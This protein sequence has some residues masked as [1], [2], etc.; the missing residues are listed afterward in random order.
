MKQKRSVRSSTRKTQRP[1]SAH[2]GWCGL[3]ALC[4]VLLANPDGAAAAS[5]TAQSATPQKPAWLTDIS[6]GLKE[7]YDNN[8]LLVSGDGMGEE[9]SWIT[10]VSPKIGIN[11]VPLLGEQDTLKL[12]TLNY[13][14]DFVAYHNAEDETYN[15]H[16]LANTL[17]G[18]VEAFTFTMDNALVYVD[19]NKTAPTYPVPDNAR[20]AYATAAA[21]ERREQFQDRAKVTLQYDWERFLI[22][23]T[24]SLLY[25]DLLT[26]QS[27][28]VGYQN[29]A[30]RYDINGGADFGYKA[31]AQTTLLL[32][33]RYGHQYQETIVGTTRSSCS[34]Y[35]RVLVGIEGKPLKWLTLSVQ[36]G[37]DFRSYD[38]DAP[39]DDQD[40]VKL[41]GEAT[42]T[43]DL[44]AKDALT[45]KYRGFQWVSSTGVIPYFDSTYDLSYRHKF[46]S[47]LTVEAGARLLTSD[48]NSGNTPTSKRNDWMYTFAG[49]VTY[50]VTA[51]FALNAAVAADLGRN[52]QKDIA[53][54]Q[55]RE[56]DRQLVSLGMTVKF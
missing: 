8:V 14:P 10:T 37:P 45:F 15:A 5:P 38:N 40:C 9:Y 43:A 31:A 33:W 51:N 16:R 24:A 35:Q 2:S 1:V 55:Y 22:R 21:R 44:S 7:G 54:E 42:V 56:F 48:Y 32:G 11:F 18:K 17:K 30:D 34:D 53:N 3:T 36:G 13:A 39:V 41:Y 25:Y 49:S 29:Y 26:D 12:L 20:S 6:L 23:P 28:A 47:K 46:G 50:S 27:T 52:Q 4:G 19:G